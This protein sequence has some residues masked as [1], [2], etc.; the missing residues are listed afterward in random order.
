MLTYFLDFDSVINHQ[1]VGL[2]IIVNISSFMNILQNIQNLYSQANNAA[3]IHLLIIIVYYLFNIFT[4]LWHNYIGH[5]VCFLT[6]LVE[7]RGGL[8]FF[9]FI[10]QFSQLHSILDYYWCRAISLNVMSR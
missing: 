3:Q 6:V 10:N 7:F 1:I 4:I 9:H 2:E 5:Y 8:T